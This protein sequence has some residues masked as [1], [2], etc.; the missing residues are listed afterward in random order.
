MSLSIQTIDKNPIVLTYIQA[1]STASGD[2]V[3]SVYFD[4]ILNVKNSGSVNTTVN[5]SAMVPCDAGDYSNVSTVVSPGTIGIFPLHSR[6]TSW[7]T[8][9][10]T[11][12]CSPVEDISLAAYR[13]LR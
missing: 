2:T 7:S 12:H 10:C 13:Q 4:V 5:I 11:I 6:I 3:S 8:K 9:V 1:N